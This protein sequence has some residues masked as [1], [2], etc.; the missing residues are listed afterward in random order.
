MSEVPNESLSPTY[1]VVTPELPADGFMFT[2]L[3][4]DRG[5]HFRVGEVARVFF[6]GAPTWWIRR[7]E[8]NLPDVGAPWSPGRSSAGDRFYSLA[9]V[10]IML[11]GFCAANLIPPDEMVKGLM[12]LMWLGRLYDYLGE[13]TSDAS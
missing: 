9:D 3:D 13:S 7:H 6:K 11:H 1:V 5:P 2:G 10:E 12:V 8:T 4:V